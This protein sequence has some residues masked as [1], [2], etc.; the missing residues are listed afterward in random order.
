M[1]KL[2]WLTDPHLNFLRP[3]LMDAF[4]NQLAEE[5]TDALIISGDIA[6][7]PNILS[8]MDILDR[9]LSCP[10]YFVLG[11]HDYYHGSIAQVR[12]D[13]RVLSA[14]APHLHWMP[15]SGV[16]A[17]TEATGLVGHGGWG[18]A[19]HGDFE[20]TPVQL[21]DHRLIEELA[22]QEGDE[23]RTRLNALGDEAADYLRGVLGSALERFEHVVVMTHVPPFVG[24]CWYQG[25]TTNDE[26]APFFTC[27][28]VGDVLLEAADAYA[29][30]STITVLCGHCHSAGVYQARPNLLVKTGGA[31]YGEPAAQP[32]VVVP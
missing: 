19:R 11:N 1:R 16:V 22:G 25:K 12:A 23:L 2:S 13:V 28:A 8:L 4:S 31:E 5:C 6:E 10:I 24:S 26:W 29:G 17:L 15:A 30:R 20:G 32:P 3:P 14:Q 27:K 21:N 9:K 18:D 7:S